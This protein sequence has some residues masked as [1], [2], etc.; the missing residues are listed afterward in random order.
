MGLGAELLDERS[1]ESCGFPRWQ[2]AGCLMLGLSFERQVT[3][4]L[5]LFTAMEFMGGIEASL[6][7]GTVWKR[8]PI[9]HLRL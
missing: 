8:R 7:Y 9:G 2:T 5:R 1:G 3:A 4:A 6:D